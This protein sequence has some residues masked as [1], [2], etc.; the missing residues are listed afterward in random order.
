MIAYIDSDERYPDF[1][2]AFEENDY[3]DPIEVTEQ[4]ELRKMSPRYGD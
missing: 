2:L 3:G 4:A 1:V